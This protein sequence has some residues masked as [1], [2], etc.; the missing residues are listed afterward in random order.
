MADDQPDRV[1]VPTLV[2][3]GGPLDGTEYPLPLTG[4]ETILGSSMDAGIQ[5]MLGNVEPFHARVLFTGDGLAIE[6][7]ES[8]TGT[9]VNGE[10]V[11]GQRP[12]QEGDR[13]CLGPPGAKGSAKLVVRLPGSASPALAADAAAPALSEAQPD[14]PAFGEAPSFA[15]EGPALAFVAEAESEAPREFDLG[16]ETVFDAESVV[17]EGDTSGPPLEAAESPARRGGGRRPLLGAAAPFRAASAAPGIPTRTFRAT[18]AATTTAATTAPA[19]VVRPRPT[20]AGG[21]ATHGAA[22]AR[23]TARAAARAR[24][25]RDGQAGVPDGAALDPRRAA[26]RA[27]GPR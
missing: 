27:Q 20:A 16:S 22:A 17:V 8:A 25:R 24:A 13:V 1:S 10:K 21:G 7:V 3:T 5:I 19:A 18:A 6:D 15:E 9:F 26:R 14:A 12:L 4:G 2:M 23:A 11:E